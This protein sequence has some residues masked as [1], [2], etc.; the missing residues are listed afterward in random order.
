MTPVRRL[1][2]VPPERTYRRFSDTFEAA[3]KQF[4]ATTKLKTT[5]G[6]SDAERAA[7]EAALA[8]AGGLFKSAVR[9]INKDAD[10]QQ[11]MRARLLLTYC[12]LQ[13]GQFYEAGIL[14]HAI[15]RWTP[16]D[17]VIGPDAASR[18]KP[19][20]E[21]TGPK[22]DRPTTAGEA[23]LAAENNN[24]GAA[25]TNVTEP[26]GDAPLRP[27]LEAAGLALAA[28][29][30]A[31]EIAPAD[32][33][34]AE[35]RAI[36]EI[37]TLY[38]TRWPQHEKA[39]SIR[40]FV[41]QLFQSRDD[42]TGAAEWYARVSRDSSDFARSRLMAGQAC[43]TA[44]LSAA[45]R[46]APEATTA[47]SESS[48]TPTVV[49]DPDAPPESEQPAPDTRLRDLSPTH[50]KQ[51]ARDFLTAGI[52]AGSGRPE[53][54]DNLAV[55]RLTLAQMYLAERDFEQTVV[56]LTTGEP[57]VIEQIG[58][59]AENRPARGTR[60][61][62][63]ARI[64][65]T[66]LI[67]A[68]LGGGQLDQASA[69]MSTL[70]DIA[71]GTDAASLAKLHLDLSEEMTRSY[72]DLAAS[73]GAD[74]ELLKIIAKSFEQLSV[75]A[76]GLSPATLLR[77]ATAATDLAESVRPPADP[78]ALFGQAAVLYEALL[79]RGLP[80]P[81]S[82]TAVRFRLADVLKRSGQFEQSLALYD[83]LLAA[84]PNV[85]SAQMKAAQALQ[86]LG[87]SSQDSQALVHA[88]TGSPQ[89][90]HLWG[91][92]RISTTLQRLLAKDPARDDYRE[93]FLEARL[94]IAECR[95]AYAGSISDSKKK[96]SELEKAL[97]ELAT[98]AYTTKSYDAPGWQSLNEIYQ[99][100]QKSLGRKPQPLY[101]VVE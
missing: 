82:E 101:T 34:E 91:W 44:S 80:D 75:N 65:Y 78:G 59:G 87:T 25:A 79:Q 94:H 24:P 51:R 40:L 98:L 42:Q 63:F 3:V 20:K 53:L 37:A 5:S 13:A 15:A 2:F 45:N 64:A 47:G 68:R 8:G 43:W 27:A 1:E 14:G 90:P 26:A 4:T 72:R 97:R 95:I 38:D 10:P 52:A 85:F 99:T 21:K 17:M 70:T 96:K 89:K 39:D 88:I 48:I 61:I 41:G 12:Y 50:L 19:E 18:T 32:D 16:D 54:S 36:L 69:A 81:G 73:G 57:T 6:N 31:R 93:R 77:A 7:W 62:G 92:G 9:Q 46:T 100:L 60:S 66:T 33:R 58:E 30:Q 11:V 83:K 55:A 76:S 74:E 84:Q 22:T 56:A 49:E 28:F 86:A 29:V 71:G 23:I 67:R 35:F